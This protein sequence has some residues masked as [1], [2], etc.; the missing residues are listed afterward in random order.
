MNK[1]VIIT[2]SVILGLTFIFFFRTESDNRKQRSI[3]KNNSIS[4]NASITE[5]PVKVT[6]INTSFVTSETVPVTTTVT[7][8]VTECSSDIVT[9]T[10]EVSITELPVTEE[11]VQGVIN[12]EI[13]YDTEYVEYPLPENPDY[14][15]FKSYEPYY[16]IT[17]Q[18]VQLC[19]QYDAVTDSSGFR[20][21]DGRYLVAV[22]TFCNAPCGT[23]IDLVLENGVLI[24]C[25]VGDIKSDAH[26]DE[27]HAYTVSTMCASEFIID[28][29]ICP[30]AWAGDISSMYPEWN[31]KVQNILVYK[32]NYF[33]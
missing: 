15:G 1:R 26:T 21:L 9:T 23:Y 8:A 18:S 25:I 30:A 14:R 12:G 27:T 11:T 6:E 29:G 10:E 4:V 7:A 13:L 31:A 22:G 32:K 17:A 2:A 19:L 16:L 28:D 20:L 3:Q 5:A 33:D 24:P